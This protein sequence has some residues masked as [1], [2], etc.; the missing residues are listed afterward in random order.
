MK[1]KEFLGWQLGR[2]QKCKEVDVLKWE[3]LLQSKCQT[4]G[5]LDGA[6]FNVQYR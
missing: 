3:N 4:G 6:I 1:R 5:M 2:K